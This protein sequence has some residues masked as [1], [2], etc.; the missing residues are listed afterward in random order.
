MKTRRRAFCQRLQN[1]I[2]LVSDWTRCNPSCASWLI[3]PF[4]E[5][6]EASHLSGSEGRSTEVFVGK[7]AKLFEAEQS[8]HQ[9]IC[10]FSCPVFN[11]AIDIEA[12]ELEI[13]LAIAQ[14]TTT[15]NPSTCV[16]DRALQTLPA[17]FSR[18]LKPGSRAWVAGNRRGH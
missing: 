4:G 13:D 9:P 17:M 3:G 11:D 5:F 16:S 2:S 10:S 7:Y 1:G 14:K 18:A 6:G 15:G 8:G 12:P